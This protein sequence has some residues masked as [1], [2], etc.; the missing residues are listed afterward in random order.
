MAFLTVL[1]II[2]VILEVSVTTIPLTLILLLNFAV[3]SRKT[4]VF[5]FAFI[6]GIL[7]DIMLGNAVGQ[8]SIF[9]IIFLSVVF[10]YDRKFD[11]QTFPFVF[12]ASF[13]GS[14]L[15]LVIYDSRLLLPTSLTSALI[16][17]FLFRLIIVADRL[18]IRERSIELE[19]EK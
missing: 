14:F 11:I 19:Y 7:I 4:Q 16:S 12:I 17:I 6:L 15:Y 8:T 1:F 13:L 2:F 5:V 10:L 18:H 9:Y 3:A